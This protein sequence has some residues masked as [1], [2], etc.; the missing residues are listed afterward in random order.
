MLQNNDVFGDDIN[1][2]ARIEPHSPIGGICISEKVKLELGSLPE[3]E[4]A[5]IGEPELKGIK[6]PVKIYC[7]SSHGLVSTYK[8]F[9][10]SVISE[11]LE[12]LSFIVNKLLG[13]PDS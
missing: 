6:Q 4:T 3:Y 7:I 12:S 1:I 10:D 8:K 13:Q 11:S 5:F 9:G 2:C